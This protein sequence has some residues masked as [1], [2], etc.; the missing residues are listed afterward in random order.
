MQNV[1][2]M[3]VS[4]LNALG[5]TMRTDSET[6]NRITAKGSDK[7]FDYTLIMQ[8]SPFNKK[9]LSITGTSN[10]YVMLTVDKK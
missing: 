9:Q 7:D 3:M 6:K 10:L 2:N 8:K 1:Y 5:I 4:D